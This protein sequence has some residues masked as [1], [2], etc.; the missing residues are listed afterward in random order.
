M[1]HRLKLLVSATEKHR[2][3]ISSLIQASSHRSL[4]VDPGTW[5]DISRD[6]NTV[7]SGSMLA[8]HRH[9]GQWSQLKCQISSFS[10]SQI[11]QEEGNNTKKEKIYEYTWI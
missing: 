2:L 8:F 9:V 11:K 5:R 7:H 3:G 10:H 6:E 4:T 1:S